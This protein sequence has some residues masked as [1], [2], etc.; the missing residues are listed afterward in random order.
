MVALAMGAGVLVLGVIAWLVLGRAEPAPS[1]ADPPAPAEATTTAPAPQALAAQ[2]DRSEVP[3]AP[4]LTAPQVAPQISAHEPTA[5]RHSA[6]A[7]AARVVEERV[8]LAGSAGSTRF[9]GAHRLSDG[10]ILVCGGTDDLAW[11][12]SASRIQLPPADLPNQ[13]GSVI[14]F[15]LHLSPDL[16]SIRSVWHF[17]KG[18]SGDICRIRSTE[19]PGTATGDLYLSGELAAYKTPKDDGYWIARLDGN[20][21]DRA[22]SRPVWIVPVKAGKR[23]AGGDSYDG[24]SDYKERQP[25]DVGNDGRVIYTTGVPHDFG[26]AALECIDANGKPLRLAR[27]PFQMTET[28]GSGVVLKAGRAG[29]LRSMTQED[30]DL[31]QEDENGNPGRK[32]RYPD[33]YYFQGPLPNSKA[34][35]YTGYRTSDKP[36]QRIGKIAIDRRDNHLYFGTSTQTKLPQGGLPDFEPAIIALDD[37]GALKWWARG[38]QEIE[39]IGA[40]ANAKVDALNSPPDQYIDGVAIDYATNRLVVVAR[41]HG[42][43]VVNFWRSQQVKNREGRE[44]FQKQFTG[45]NGNAHYS[46]LGRY[47]LDGGKITAASYLADLGDYLKPNKRYP[48][49]HALAGWPDINDAWHNLQ[50][51][52]VADVETDS[53]GRTLV[54]GIGKRSFTTVDAKIP[55]LIPTGG[56]DPAAAWCPFVRVYDTD[57]GG[58]AYSSIVRGPWAGGDPKHEIDLNAVLPLADGVLCVGTHTSNGGG[59]NLPTSG[60]PTW[61]SGT[62]PGAVSGVLAILRVKGP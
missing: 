2:P 47:T 58:I 43:G 12:A 34:P 28:G 35:G 40:N 48:A 30:F 7:V 53:Y 10:S 14:G 37:Q 39:R 18:A 38:Y 57:L 49:G 33:D 46:W 6:A 17:P 36:T 24:R 9:R 42:N 13:T 54:I 5:P 52:R 3:A 55:N 4:S 45:T 27:M 23:D 31:R 8:L 21:V 25:W 19:V 15:V 26:W 51:T 1:M 59:S 16:A 22:P 44:G 60:V 62:A 32:G 41:C 29:S 11:T 56:N 61:A 50:T 20:A